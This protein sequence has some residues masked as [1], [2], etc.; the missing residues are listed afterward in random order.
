M[1]TNNNGATVYNNLQSDMHI[2]WYAPIGG[3]VMLFE[4]FVAMV[5]TTVDV[6]I[7]ADVV[8]VSFSVMDCLFIIVS[9]TQLQL[10]YI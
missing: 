3:P 8:I 2:P 1:P 9:A 4:E 5:T 10:L 6:V 7:E